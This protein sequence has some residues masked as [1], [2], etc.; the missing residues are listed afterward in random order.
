MAKERNMK[1]K[2]VASLFM[3]AVMA[4]TLVQVQL[5]PGAAA[6]DS[7]ETTATDVDSYSI[8]S[9][10]NAYRKYIARY[11]DAIKPME[12][13]TIDVTDF[14]QSGEADVKLESYEGEDN[15]VAWLDCVGTLTWH[16]HV[17]TTGI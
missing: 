9:N 4:T 6:E 7:F 13:V 16:I 15:C 12:E 5:A 17:I 3:S 10:K 2:R 8:V 11:P 14:D 1:L